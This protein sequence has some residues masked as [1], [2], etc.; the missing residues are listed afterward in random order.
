MIPK[1][2]LYMDKLTLSTCFSLKIKSI[3]EGTLQLYIYIL[4]GRGRGDSC[5][6]LAMELHVPNS[7]NFQG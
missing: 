3:L 2:P 7:F 1:Y 5:S 4:S 6:N